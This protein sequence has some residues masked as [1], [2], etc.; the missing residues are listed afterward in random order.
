MFIYLHNAYLQHDRTTSFAW[1]QV[2]VVVM[3][4]E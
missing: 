3:E 2:V 1:E 4:H